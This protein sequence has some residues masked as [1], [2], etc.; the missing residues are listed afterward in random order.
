MV[1]LLSTIPRQGIMP[2]SPHTVV[3]IGPSWV[4]LKSIAGLP[5]AKPRLLSRLVREN[6]S[7]FFLRMNGPMVVSEVEL[8]RNG[9]AWSA[10]FDESALHEIRHGLHRS[11][12]RLAAAVPAAGVIAS[13]VEGSF[14]WTDGANEVEIVASDGIVD[15]IRLRSRREVEPSRCPNSIP[16]ALA[17]LGQEAW[18]YA[19]AYAA[20]RIDR[21]SAFAWRPPPDPRRSRIKKRLGSAAAF[22]TVTAAILTMLLAPGI[23]ASRLAARSERELVSLRAIQTEI[24]RTQGELR[25]VT[26]QIEAVSRFQVDRGGITLLLGALARTLPESTAVVSLRVDSLEGSVVA[27]ALHATEIVPQL[28]RLDRVLSPRVVGSITTEV[29]GGARLE[30]VTIRFRRPRVGQRGDSAR[31]RESVRAFRGQ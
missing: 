6:A 3:A 27:L 23:R 7:S 1:E 31:S 4:Q 10:A 22:V 29:V 18:S 25:R 21:N 19:A 9:S 20:T 24:A 14:T 8:R 15:R 5:K 17:T 12:L 16:P 26:S 13:I 11:G 2:I 30:R 28:V